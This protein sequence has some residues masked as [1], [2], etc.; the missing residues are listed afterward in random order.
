MVDVLPHRLE[1]LLD[2]IGPHQRRALVDAGFDGRPLRWVRVAS[3]GVVDLEKLR[4]LGAMVTPARRGGRDFL[5]A[6]T[7][8]GDRIEVDLASALGPVD[9]VDDF[10]EAFDRA[11]QARRVSNSVACWFAAQEA[12]VALLRLIGQRLGLGR[13]DEGLAVVRERVP[14]RLRDALRELGAGLNL[15][16]TFA[17]L[18]STLAFAAGVAQWLGD[19]RAEVLAREV[20]ILGQNL[21]ADRYWN[22]RDVATWWA[23]HV[24]PGVLWRGR[25]PAAYAGDGFWETARA[26]GLERYVDLRGTIERME[27]SYPDGFVGCVSVPLGG[28]PRGG[29]LGGRDLDESYRRLVEKAPPAIAAVLTAIAETEGPTLVHCRAGVDRTGVVVALIGLWLGVP[30]DRIVADYLASGQLVEERRLRIAF[31]QVRAHGERGIDTIIAAT[32]VPE[33]VLSVARRRFLI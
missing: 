6:R 1:R 24:R 11:T 29:G 17:E 27:L 15:R 25:P 3:S 23:P 8:E 30:E 28:D 5:L 7:G 10:V 33:G 12:I 21:D 4:A 19:A 31:E 2:E 26:A 14:Q 16:D 22:L 13:S 32:G 18:K 20:E 9:E